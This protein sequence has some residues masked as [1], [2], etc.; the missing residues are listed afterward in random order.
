[1]G[2]GPQEVNNLT[3]E[4]LL[5]QEQLEEQIEEQ[6]EEQTKEQLEEQTLSRS[7]PSRR[8][9]HISSQRNQESD[10]DQDQDLSP[11]QWPI[12]DRLTLA[13]VGGPDL[14]SPPHRTLLHHLHPP[15]GP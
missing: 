15:A 5:A 2:S 6:L 14:V 8:S 7:Q 12:V 11:Y 9:V 10:Q 13:T 1:M 3:R 4:G